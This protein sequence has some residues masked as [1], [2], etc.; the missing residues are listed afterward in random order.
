MLAP[1]RRAL[2]LWVSGH[3]ETKDSVWLTLEQGRISYKY[4]EMGRG[5]P[6][7][8]NTFTACFV[9]ESPLLS[10]TSHEAR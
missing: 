5:C 7:A 10:N 3:R 9:H 6:K 1:I 4:T 8:H 2:K